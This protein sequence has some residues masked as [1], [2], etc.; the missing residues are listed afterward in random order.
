MSESVTMCQSCGMPFANPDDYGTE[1]DGTKSMIYCQ[2]CYQN[3]QFTNSDITIEEMA[4]QG[5]AIISKMFEIPAQKAEAFALQQLR[6]LK[7][8]S[9]KIIPSCESCG[10]PLMTDEDAGTEADG[11]KSCRYCTHCYQNGVFT[12]PDLT[13]DGMI[14]KYAPMI[15]AELDISLQKAEE[16]VTIFTS[17]LPRWK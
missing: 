6:P 11:T 10:M 9:G 5:A 14:Q 2:Y 1:S 12:E 16:M 8:W 4:I 17:S 3:G 13:R 15:S 7:R